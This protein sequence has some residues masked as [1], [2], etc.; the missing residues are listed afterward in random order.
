ME[1]PWNWATMYGVAIVV[2]ALLG[3][4]L[5]KVPLF[6]ETTVAVGSLP[7]F[8]KTPVADMRLSASQA[9]LYLG[10][11]SALLLF[12][13]AGIRLA[14]QIPHD[15]KGRTVLRCLVPPLITLLVLSVGY[16]AFL[17]PG[18]DPPFT[19]A[20]LELYNWV[21]V[22]TTVT[23]S[24]WLTMAWFRHSAPLFGVPAVR[25]QS[26][27]LAGLWKGLRGLSK[28][29]RDGGTAVMLGIARSDHPRL[30][31]HDGMPPNLGRY[32]LI[33][34]L[35]RG[36]MAVVYLGK[37]PKIQRSVA[38][39][40]MRFDEVDPDELAEVKGRFFREAESA[41]QLSHP[42]IVTIYDAGEEQGLAY[43]AMELLEGATLKDWCRKE[44]LLPVKRVLEIGAQVS[45]ALYYAHRRG[46]VHRD[47]KPANIMMTKEG[48]VKVADFGIA[49][50]SSS[51]KTQTGV[52]LGTPSYM[53]P[54]QLSGS[55]V[56]GRSDLFSLG[57]VL[58]ELLT[59]EKPFQGES[60]ATLMFKIA[61][62]P[63]QSASK[64]RQDLPQYCRT[65][66]NRAL[67]K[68]PAKRYQSG[69]ELA[70]ALSASH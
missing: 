28:S 32:A 56:D 24:I 16:K 27:I 12:W 67:Q 51:S 45:E 2:A 64:I 55:T 31:T 30:T 61:H 13:I 36:A 29:F 19:K 26:G 48:T 39:K 59:G 70:T 43:I 49:R 25:A 34:E 60:I 46:I 18:H 21:F 10:Y 44:N 33:S 47:I 11:G 35:G 63:H 3:F 69:A 65:I 14:R 7:L 40:A 58:F 54:E 5:G 4:L 57:V 8:Q 52:L 68:D 37:D 17:P 66:I 53:S 1:R 62:K 23:A 6:K 42:N 22:L 50:L 20:A 9:V 38:I 41:G 15:G